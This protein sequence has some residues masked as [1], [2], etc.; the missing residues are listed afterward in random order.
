[1]ISSVIRNLPNQE[2]GGILD[3]LWLEETVLNETVSAAKILRDR[4]TTLD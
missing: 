4:V 1:M 2:N 3:R